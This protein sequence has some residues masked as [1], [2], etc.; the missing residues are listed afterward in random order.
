MPK[1]KLLS[2]DEWRQLGVQ[3][4]HGWEHYMI[5]TP[6]LFS[7]SFFF[8]FVGGVLK[9]KFFFSPCTEPHILLF[10][11]ELDYAQKYGDRPR[12]AG[13]STLQ[14]NK[15]NSRRSNTTAQVQP[16]YTLSKR[17]T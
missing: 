4:S 2:E 13:L 12:P 8:C 1:D 14:F 11:R 17:I 10:R 15:E 5:H 16:K 6:G 7:L 9:K 3:Q